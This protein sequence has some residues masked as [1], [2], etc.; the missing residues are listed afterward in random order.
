MSYLRFA[1]SAC[2]VVSIILA[3]HPGEANAQSLRG[4][5]ATVER[6]HSHASDNSIYFYLTSEGIRRAVERGALV[7][8]RPNQD[9][10]MHAVSHP[11][12]LP[13]TLTFVERL[14][15]QYR[16]ACGE[17][18]VVTSASRPRSMRLSNSVAKSVHPTGMAVD[19]RRPQNPRCRAWL[20]RTLLSLDAANVIEAIEEFRPPHF[21]VAVF[22]A[23]Y[24]QYVRR[25]GGTVR[26]AA[27]TT[28]GSDNYRVRSGDSLWAIA[29]RH[30][31]TVD[32][33]RTANQLSSNSLRPGQELVIPGR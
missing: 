33:L 8:L 1:I 32:R 26:V 28:A 29:R 20:H 21:H 7:R 2:L 5:R 19:L 18:L 23:P 9:Y 3:F 31:T 13:A 11:Y 10:T 27:A 15:S 17:R 25:R 24:T 22:P 14:A 6:M 16:K 4:S 12:V 30:G